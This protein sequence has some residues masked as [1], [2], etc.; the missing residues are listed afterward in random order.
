MY[1]VPPND[2]VGL[3]VFHMQGLLWAVM[4]FVVHIRQI[5]NV[6]VEKFNV[7]DIAND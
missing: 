3:L 4:T 7:R 5:Y 1:R 6:I 2:K